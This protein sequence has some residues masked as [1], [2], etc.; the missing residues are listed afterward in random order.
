MCC[1][2]ADSSLRIRVVA[3]ESWSDTYLLAVELAST[4]L[5]P[6]AFLSSSAFTLP[7]L[8]TSDELL[9]RVVESVVISLDKEGEREEGQGQDDQVN[10]EAERLHDEVDAM[11]V[12][13]AMFERFEG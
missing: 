5:P 12:Y 7:G 8:A 2:L 11:S 6:A 1:Q 10:G 13:A 4:A 3:S 9:K